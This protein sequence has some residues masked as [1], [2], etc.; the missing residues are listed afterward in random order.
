[1][2][3][4]T[5]VDGF[6]GGFFSTNG[7]VYSSASNCTPETTTKRSGTYSCKIAT[8]ASTGQLG[9]PAAT[10]TIV[11]RVYLNFSVLPNALARIINVTNTGSSSIIAY[12]PADG[13]LYSYS[14]STKGNACSTVLSTNTWYRIDFR[15][16]YN[17]S[18]STI[19]FQVDGTAATQYSPSNSATAGS[20][21][22]FGLYNNAVTSTIFLDDLV[23]STTSADYPIGPGA[24][25]VILPSSDGTHNGGTNTIEDNT[26]TDIVSPTYTTAWDLINDV[27]MSTTT[28][29]IQQASGGAGNGNYAEVNFADTSNTTIHGAMAY[30]SYTSS[31]TQANNGQLDIID[32]DSTVTNVYD[33]DMSESSVFYKS[34]ILPNPAGGWDQGAVNALKSRIGYS[35]D[36]SPLPRWHALQIQVAYATTSSIDLVVADSSCTSQTDALGRLVKNSNVVTNDSFSTSQTDSFKLTKNSSVSVL[37]SFVTSQADNTVLT[38]TVNLTVQDSSCISQADNVTITQVVGP[39][40]LVVADSFSTSQVDI[41]VVTKES[42]LVVDD[43]F[44]TDQTDNITLTITLLSRVKVTWLTL[45]IPGVGVPTVNTND[46]SVVTQTDNVTLTQV[47]NL[48]V[49][50]ASCV[51]QSDSVVLVLVRNLVVQDSFSTSQ[52][53][54]VLITKQSSLVLADSF[55]SSQVDFVLVSKQSSL[56]LADSFS[57]SQVDT[58]SLIKQSTLVVLDSFSTS[59]ADALILTKQSSIV[60]E[61]SFS[62]SQSDTITLVRNVNLLVADIFSTSQSDLVLV[63]KQS[64]LVID[65]SYSTSQV[66][67]ATVNAFKTLVIQDSFVTSQTDTLRL[68]VNSDVVINDAYST[69]FV[70]QVVLSTLT[71]LNVANTFVTTQ[72]DLALITKQ[73]SLVLVDAFSDTQ[74]DFIGITKQSDLVLLDS[75]VASQTDN[76]V[77][78]KQTSV[79]INDLFSTTQSDL[80]SIT[81]VYTAVI[82]DAYSI[83]FA[84]IANLTVIG[85]DY[86]RPTSDIYNGNWTNELGGTDLYNSIDETSYS[87]SDYIQSEL[88]PTSSVAVIA[89]ETGIDPVMSTGHILRYRY[90]KEPG[91]AEAINFTV[92]LRENYINEGNQGTLVAEWIHTDIP[93]TYTLAEQT[94]NET[95]ADSITSYSNLFVRMIAGV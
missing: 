37:D 36:A 87:D 52:S 93:A 73:S 50:D 4:L 80:A 41:P 63:T 45:K 33:G 91:N 55:S 14:S 58:F 78:T 15:V 88:E 23:L 90:G 25:E 46:S 44:S 76:V 24:V 59:Q 74:I 30:M 29:Y 72:S 86:L 51:S 65:D 27:P 68:F 79:S 60:V 92:Q 13:K 10:A 47:H 31:G 8:T 34:K 81:V 66:D 17:G 77:T 2:A 48:T 49:N 57:T 18:T 26:G 38:R 69:S 94:L 85:V 39:K 12:D 83:S 28:E 16:T 70:D 3:T 20:I 89:L 7:G 42:A 82:Q 22:Y 32:E 9:Y 6:E 43:S 67:I 19:D 35:T 40:N 62:A 53:D 11:G 54:L 1:M 61:D 5:L 21:I 84:D 95:Q 71:Y 64:S 75:F 56:V